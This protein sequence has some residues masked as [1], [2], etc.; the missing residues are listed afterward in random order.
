MDWN[1]NVL[2]FTTDVNL[3]ELA[4]DNIR[5]SVAKLQVD[6]LVYRPPLEFYRRLFRFLLTNQ[7]ERGAVYTVSYVYAPLFEGDAMAVAVE[8]RIPLVLAGYSP[9]QPDPQRMFYEFDEALLW[10]T[11]WT[12]PGLAQAGS[13]SQAELGRFWNPRTRAECDFRPRYLAPFH[14]IDYEQDD[15]IEKVFNLGLVKARKNA[16]PVFSNYPINWLLMYSDL[17]NFGY[18]PYAPEFSTLIREGRASRSYWQI[19]APMVDLMIRRRLFLGRHV[20][21]HQR[22]LGLSD[23]DLLINRPRG[24][25]DPV[26]PAPGG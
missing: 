3:P 25:Y 16:S 14:V 12:P 18:N 21:E 5:R 13:F 9:G 20:T 2:A 8:K 7:E 15:V 6:H 23:E 24:A 17:K 1:L 19:M 4:W 11:D 22:W 26:K 10:S